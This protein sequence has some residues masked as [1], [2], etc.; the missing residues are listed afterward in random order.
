MSSNRDSSYFANP[1]ESIEFCIVLYPAHTVP[2][3]EIYQRSLTWYDAHSSELQSGHAYHKPSRV[4]PNPHLQ[5]SIISYL[6]PHR[7]PLPGQDI[8][9]KSILHHSC[10]NSG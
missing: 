5:S 3:N 7:P 1:P 8:I 2:P 9:S 4:N 10:P 6:S